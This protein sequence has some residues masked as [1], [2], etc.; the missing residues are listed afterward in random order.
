VYWC[1]GTR[2]EDG[3]A[4]ADIAEIDQ[5]MNKSRGKEARRHVVLA[6]FYLTY[7]FQTRAEPD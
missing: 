1:I 6:C 2:G 4:L 3:E 7:L 5:K